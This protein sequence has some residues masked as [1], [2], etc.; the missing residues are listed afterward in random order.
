VRVRL[1]GEWASIIVIADEHIQPWESVPTFVCA[2][3]DKLMYFPSAGELS[4]ALLQVKGL[5]ETPSSLRLL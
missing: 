2:P 1:G 4:G 3:F 5:S